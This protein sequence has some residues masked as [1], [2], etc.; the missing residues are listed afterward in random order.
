MMVNNSTEL[1]DNPNWDYTQQA[2]TYHL[3]PN[4]A[5]AA[6]DIL[7]KKVQA[8]SNS[9]YLIADVGAGTA[10]LTLMFLERNFNCVAI[11]PN[12]AMRKMGLQRTQG[13]AVKWIEATGEQ[14]C[15]PDKSIDL[16]AMGSSFNCTDPQKT[17]VEAHRVLKAGG[18]FT[19]MWNNRDLENDPV[20]KQVENII[21]SVIP[22]YE[23]GTRRQDQTSTI[24]AS[25]LFKDVEYFE[26]NQRVERTVQQYIET[27]KSVRNQYWDLNTLEGRQLFTK[28]LDLVY[29]EIKDLPKL[30]LTYMTRVWIAKRV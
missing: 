11:E 21:C 30:E 13:M 27:W 7:C 2:A 12:S 28:I 10:N 17:L 6:I 25:N 9:D 14:T 18:Y 19:C 23:G 8:Q 5:E 1:N 16:F 3:R 26:I 22:N 29:Q 24:L 4:Y 15:L 20:Q